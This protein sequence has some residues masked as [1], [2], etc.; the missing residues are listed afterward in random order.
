M[1]T[2]IKSP[3]KN[4]VDHPDCDQATLRTD[5]PYM[6]QLRVQ[7]QSACSSSSKLG[8]P[9]SR[10]WWR[11]QFDLQQLMLSH[12]GPLRGFDMHRHVESLRS[13]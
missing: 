8:V 1:V 11:G 9:S 10:R 3:N 5:R 13:A 4:P 7:E 2:Q 6:R 12:I